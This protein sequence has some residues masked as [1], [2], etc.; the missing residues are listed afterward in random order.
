VLALAFLITPRGGD[1]PLVVIAAVMGAAAFNVVRN[2]PLAVIAAVAPLTR[3]LHLIRIKMRRA[4]LPPSADL[5]PAAATAEPGDFNRIGQFVILAA[6]LALTLGKWGLLSS[7]LPAAMDYPAGPVAFMR[8]HQLS[9]NLLARFEWGQYLIFHLAP[10]SKIFVDGRVDQLY[11]PEVI[12]EY[13]DFFAGRPGGARLLE[14]YPHDYVLMPTGSPP[15]LLL[16][17]RRD[18]RPI[19]RDPVAVLFAP[20]ASPAAHLPGVPINAAAPPSTFP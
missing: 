18:W 20:A 13:L 2:M 15:D 4:V 8:A 5:T 6:A 19:Y 9:G 17:A 16:S 10:S 7:Q 12:N 1:L 3:H 14:R 11:P